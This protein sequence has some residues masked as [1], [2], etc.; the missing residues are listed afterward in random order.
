MNKTHLY[1]TCVWLFFPMGLLTATSASAQQEAVAYSGVT[2]SRLMFQE[3][4][5][6]CHGEDLEGAA[7]GTPLRGELGHGESMADVVASIANGYIDSG[8]PSWDDIFSPVQIQG[9]AMYV[10]ETRANVG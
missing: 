2:A 10:L 9:L 5:A 3:N 4:C 1:F 7:Q 6:V 8:M